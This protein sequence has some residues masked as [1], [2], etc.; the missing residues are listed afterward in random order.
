GPAQRREPGAEV[1]ALDPG[2]ARQQHLV[3]PERRRTGLDVLAEVHAVDRREVVPGLERP[4]ALLADRERLHRVAGAALPALEGLRV[5]EPAHQVIAP[6]DAEPTV[7]AYLA[8]APKVY[9]G[10][11]CVQASR[12]RASSDSST[13]RSILRFAA[14]IRISSPSRTSAIGPATKASGATWPTEYPL[15]APLNRP[16]VTRATSAPRPA[17]ATAAVTASISGMPGEP[18]GPS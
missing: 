17:R 11:G 13:S 18:F 5:G 10:A 7:R 8:S 16:S 15:V 12:R 14:S 2:T 3:A 6:L 4:E 9:R 1:H